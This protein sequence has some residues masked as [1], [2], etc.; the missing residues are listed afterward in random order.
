MFEERIEGDY[1]IR[2][3]PN[4]TE[5]KTLITHETEGEV[6]SLPSNPILALQEEN[7]ILKESQALM[8]AAL[9]ELIM[10]GGL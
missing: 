10:G 6:I 9:D 8:Q 5:V 7:R 1:I 2:T 4:G 3:Y